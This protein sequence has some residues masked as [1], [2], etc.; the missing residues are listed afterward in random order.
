MNSPL[1]KT[2]PRVDQIVGEMTLPEKIGQMTQV[3]ND[4]ISTTDVAKRS[5]GSVLSGGNGNPS[6]NTPQAWVDMVGEFLAG[7]NESRLGVP[8]LYG[9]DAVHG[10]SNVGGATIFPH[11]IGL[12]A[13]G[14]GNLVRAIGRATAR[15][16]L[17][18]GVQWTFAPTVAVPRDIRWGR[19]YEGFGA[20]T[21]LVT[22]LGAAMIEGLQDGVESGSGVLAC[23]KHYLGDGATTWG[24]VAR[25]DSPDWWGGWGSNWQIDQGDVL[26]SER[27][28]RSDHLPP[29]ASA[30]DA[31]VMTVMAS[32]NSWHGAKVHGHHGLLTDVLKGELGFT[33]FVVSDWMGIDQLDAD[34][35]TS[36][37]ASI[38]AGIDMVMVPLEW[39]RFIDSLTRAVAGGTVPMDRIDDA[40]SRILHAK[41][42]AGLFLD[43]S[44]RP[45]VDVIGAAE[46]RALAEEAVRKSAVLLKNDRAL[47]MGADRI[48]VAGVAADDIG[49]Q[50]G[51][52]TVGW[53][54]GTGP[55]TD[56]STLLD[57]LSTKVAVTY[58]S[59]GN[60][61]DRFPVGVVCIAE[62]PYAEGP[63]D[64]AEPTVTEDDRAT[65]MRMRQHCDTLVLV[66]YSGRP[67]LVRDLIDQSD[68]V[69]AAWLPG[70]EGA[71]LADLLVGDQ[72][73]A[74][75]TP[76]PWP[77]SAGDLGSAAA[78]ALFPTGHGLTR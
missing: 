76:Q 34:Y 37:A 69:V 74:S 60:V 30:I 7:A 49:L 50:C 73:F 33:G 77:A 19:T 13:T 1:T 54:G 11:N 59:D 29:Y 43:R 57:G 42:G 41:I 48:A 58:A 55:T 4:S 39:E 56:G 75:R 6:P 44:A 65:F 24:T 27:Q 3:S 45:S 53:Q 32:Y 38:N 12:G 20:D 28:L 5:I 72:P 71:A 21:A 25:P 23:A 46:H 68:A 64:R 52:W 62:E 15:E 61:D 26:L 51:G 16:M 2:S 9:V 14:D 66:I 67:L 22:R 17:A 70:S 78:P 63:G 8:L 35:D 31:G 47:P 40:V 18:T 10:H 36:V